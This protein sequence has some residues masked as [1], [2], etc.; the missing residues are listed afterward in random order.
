MIPN[1]DKERE[2]MLTHLKPVGKPKITLFKFEAKDIKKRDVT[3]F[4]NLMIK[5]KVKVEVVEMP[6]KL[7]GQKANLV[8][9]DEIVELK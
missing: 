2:Y 9:V 8:I 5:L 3:R 7:K 4:K 1:K 6:K